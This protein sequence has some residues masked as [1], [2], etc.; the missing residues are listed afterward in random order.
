MEKLTRE[1]Y[2]DSLTRIVLNKYVEAYVNNYNRNV[3]APD[4]VALGD[5]VRRNIVPQL[6]EEET[7]ICFEDMNASYNNAMNYKENEKEK[8][9]IAAYDEMRDFLAKSWLDFHKN[10]GR[11]DGSIDGLGAADILEK[12]LNK[13]KTR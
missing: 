8:P 4:V 9:W 7:I 11:F 10:G 3:L 13:A 2:D 5:I 1:N 6:S 12:E